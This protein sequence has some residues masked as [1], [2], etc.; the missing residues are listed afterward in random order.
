MKNI[1]GYLITGCSLLEPS[2]Y[3][4]IANLNSWPLFDCESKNAQLLSDELMELLFAHT[5]GDLILAADWEYI[6]RYIELCKEE[7]IP[8][9]VFV[10]SVNNAQKPLHLHS[11][12]NNCVS[13]FLGVDYLA[14]VDASYLFD[15]GNTLFD[16]YPDEL[17]PVKQ[18]IT[19]NG[20]LASI[21]D[22]QIY[23]GLRRYLPQD[24]KLEYIGKEY[25][26]SVYELM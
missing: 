10:L 6:Q 2:D 15:D 21:E 1:Y 12:N 24:G 26:I 22:A 4:G 18:R 11:P 7:N 13:H 9:R 3:H 17:G 16:M 25:I 23:A 8:V 20:L 19:E 5:Y 14:S